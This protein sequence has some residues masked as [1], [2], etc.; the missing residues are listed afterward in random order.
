MFHTPTDHRLQI[1]PSVERLMAF[2][3]KPLPFPAGMDLCR[4][5]VPAPTDCDGLRFAAAARKSPARRALCPMFTADDWRVF[6]SFCVARRLPAGYRVAIPGH[7]D[8]ALRFVVEGSLW[9]ASAGGGK[10]LLAGAMLGEDGMFSDLA[11][12]ADVRTVEES[13]VLE[14]SLPRQKELTASFPAIAFELLRAAGAVDR[15]ARP[16]RGGA[17]EL[18]VEPSRQRPP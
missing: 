8:R 3:G 10:A 18:V 12:D 4:E 7:V 5:Q 17:D 6:S 13:L 11:G 1:S 2:V 14:L 16:P 9:Q 15:R